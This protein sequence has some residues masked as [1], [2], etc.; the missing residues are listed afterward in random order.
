[1]H[2]IILCL[3]V[4]AFKQNNNNVTSNVFGN[5]DRESYGHLETDGVYYRWGYRGGYECAFIVVVIGFIIWPLFFYGTFS[6][7]K[8]DD[9]VGA[10]NELVLS[11]WFIS[12]ESNTVTDTRQSINSVTIDK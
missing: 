6:M 8:D 10:F 9:F 3:F 2:V 11:H 7:C 12:M 1:M 5:C 4:D